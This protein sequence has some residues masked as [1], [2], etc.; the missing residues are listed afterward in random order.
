MHRD[1]KAAYAGA[2]RSHWSSNGR[3]LAHGPGWRLWHDPSQCAAQCSPSKTLRWALWPG[4]PR[5]RHLWPGSPRCRHSP[6]RGPAPATQPRA[7]SRATRIHTAESVTQLSLLSRSR[8][9]TSELDGAAQLDRTGRLACGQAHEGIRDDACPIHQSTP[10]R[11]VLV[12]SS[13]AGPSN[14]GAAWAQVSGSVGLWPAA[15]LACGRRLARRHG[16]RPRAARHSG[17]RRGSRRRRA[18]WAAQTDR[19]G[20]PGPPHGHGRSMSPS[21]PHGGERVER[22]PLYFPWRPTRPTH[23][24]HTRHTTR[25]RVAGR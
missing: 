21:P 25:R 24:H 2:Y 16:I 7:A 14:P 22:L 13:R 9:A 6:A 5:C 15:A 4:S 17:A 11:A 23:P 8:R 1:I 3:R 19:F 12:S 10:I 20:G 18:S